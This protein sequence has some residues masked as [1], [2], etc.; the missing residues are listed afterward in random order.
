MPRPAFADLLYDTAGEDLYRVDSGATMSR[1]SYAGTER[2]SIVREGSVVRFSARARYTRV[3]PD[4]KSRGE[5]VFVQVLHPDGTF[6]DRVDNDPDFLTVLNQPFAIRLDPATLRDL[7][8][9][10]G[11]VP[12]SAGSPLGGEAVLRGFLRPGA[13]GPIDGQPTTA[14]RFE[15]EGPMNGTLPGYADGTVSGTM[16]MDGTAYYALDGATLLALS[17]TL[18]LDARFAQGRPSGSVPIRI[19]YRRSMRATVRTPPPAPL[20]TG[21]GT[22]A[23]ATP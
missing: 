5:A 2:L 1:V 13:S 11:R 16:R 3:G 20:A 12:F 8:A 15:A 21:G 17:V 23:P 19:T 10:H 22:V 7:R 6:E 14:V 18:A 9:L 4:G